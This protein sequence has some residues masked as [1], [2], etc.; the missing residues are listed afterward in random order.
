MFGLLRRLF[1]RP[2]LPMTA[3][4]TKESISPDW[5]T[6]GR[7]AASES[8]SNNPDKIAIK[9]AFKELYYIH[10]LACKNAKVRPD[11]SYRSLR[12]FVAGWQ[13]WKM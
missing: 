2:E 11:D 8:Q 13:E 6:L 7:E 5:Y 10:Q 9:K 12:R 3:T 1:S 4:P